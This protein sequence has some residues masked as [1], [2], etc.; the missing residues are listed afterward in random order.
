MVQRISRQLHIPEPNT[1]TCWD[2]RSLT[3]STI[4]TPSKAIAS[5]TL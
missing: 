2:D 4:K 1:K 3:I 5:T